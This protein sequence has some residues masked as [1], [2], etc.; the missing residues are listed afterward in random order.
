MRLIVQDGEEKRAIRLSP[1][2]LTV[3]SA[4]TA[5]VRLSAPGVAPEHL[6]IHVE[7]EGVEI[8][9]LAPRHTTELSGQAIEGRVDWPHG[10][11]LVVGSARMKADLREKPK[12]AAPAPVR[13][14]APRGG[15]AEG[16][17]GSARGASGGGARP[18]RVQRSSRPRAQ[19]SFPT[20]LIL[21]LAVPAILVAWKAFQ[22]VAQS[23]ASE[24]FAPKTSEERLVEAIRMGDTTSAEVE[25][26][27]VRANW[28]S[29]TPEWT[30]RFE[31]LEK[32]IKKEVAS[33]DAFMIEAEGEKHIDMRLQRFIDR[34]LR[35]NGRPEAREFM[36]RADRFLQLYPG[37]SKTDWVERMKAQFGKYAKMNEPPTAEDLLFELK[38][39]TE[40]SP[41]DYHKAHEIIAAFQ[42]DNGPT[43]EISAFA[44]GLSASEEEYYYREM[45][46]AEGLWER[47]TAGSQQKALGTALAV[48][49]C[50]SRDDL[51]EDGVAKLKGVHDIQ[52]VLR[53]LQ[54][55][56]EW[57]EP[58]EQCARRPAFKAFLKE[59]GL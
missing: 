49:A 43:P 32:Q 51:A 58:L 40:G 14:G 31:E 2:T 53:A 19:R 3:G 47:E 8:E 27:K 16:R 4:E 20:W 23:S 34:N 41:R 18:A 9:V 17:S 1:G 44:A 46:L 10:A 7:G 39:L 59:M 25:M 38:Y 57:A 13:S 56:P 21:L 22:S 50:L 48:M 29:L 5:A 6:A 28:K 35:E 26:A 37:H 54:K 15:R 55:R 30:A 24:G 36:R 52:N 12:A 42:K 11:L 45:D 33:G